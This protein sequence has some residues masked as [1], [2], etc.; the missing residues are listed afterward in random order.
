MGGLTAP[1]PL[2]AGHQLTRFDCGNRALNVWLK[3]RAL[4][5]QASGASRTFV[6]CRN[7]RV[8]GY[9]A[10]ATGS[11]ERIAAPG[12]IRRNMPE[13]VPVMV[14]GRLAVDVSM[15]RNR[16]GSRLLKD[17]LLRTVRVSKDAGIRAM[18]VHAISDEAARFYK[19]RGF[20]PSPLDSMTLMLP[21]E[22]V[23]RLIAGR[24]RNA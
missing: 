12:R 21:L 23:E 14:L 17:A 3:D 20:Q 8:V 4:K 7:G 10:L 24:V 5:N 18:L 6:V 15:Q 13:S 19:R 1:V 11:I 2:T 16:L 9:Y 22:H